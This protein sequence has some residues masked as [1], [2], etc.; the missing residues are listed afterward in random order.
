MEKGDECFNK[1]S[2]RKGGLQPTCRECQAAYRKK[3]REYFL[4]KSR[5]H[6]AKNIE[7]ERARRAAYTAK[8]IERVRAK[9]RRHAASNR[10]MYAAT[11]AK[12]RATQLQATPGWADL[13]K[14]RAFYAA[15]NFLSMVT[16]EWYHVDHT[17]PLLG[18]KARSGPFKGERLVCGLHCESN[19]CVVLGKENLSKSNLCWP[20]MP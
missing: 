7:S 8:N 1:H 12:R 16:G 6:Y 2:R 19:L 4:E 11:E 17:V 20:D 14:I 3:N 5:A 13:N 15:S 18:P 10:H 9:S